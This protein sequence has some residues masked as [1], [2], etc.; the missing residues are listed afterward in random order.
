[1]ERTNC[2]PPGEAWVPQA[3]HLPCRCHARLEHKDEQHFPGF[4]LLKST[5]GG[6]AIPPHCLYAT[7]FLKLTSSFAPSPKAFLLKLYTSTPGNQYLLPPA[8]HTARN[9]KKEWHKS[10]MLPDPT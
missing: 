10:E 8:V 3:P 4:G 7:S 9:Q 2:R 6:C 5:A 1:M